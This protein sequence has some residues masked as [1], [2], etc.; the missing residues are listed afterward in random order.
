MYSH[1]NGDQ[2]LGASARNARHDRGWD[3]C[4][5]YQWTQKDGTIVWFYA[6]FAACS[7][8]PGYWGR[9]YQ[10]VGRNV[11]NY[12]LFT[13]NWV[14]G[15]A[16]SIQNLSSIT[17]SHSDGHS[18]TLTFGL[19]NGINE[20]TSIT[21]PDNQTT[22]GYSYDS[23][24]DLIGVTR[25]G[26]SSNA[27]L[28]E[29]YTYASGHQMTGAAGPRATTSLNENGGT[30]N[31][32]DE[33]LFF[34]N[35]SDQTTSLEDRGVVNFAPANDGLGIALQTPEPTGL[36]YWRTEGFSGYNGNTTVTDT[37]GHARTWTYDGSGRG[38]QLQAWSS[39]N[40]SL[41]TIAAW[42]S[43]NDLLSIVDPR[44]NE[45]DYG[46][47]ARG[48]LVAM[49]QPTVTTSSGPLRPTTTYSYDGHN[50][51]LSYCDPV[52]NATNSWYNPANPPPVCPT[53]AGS[54]GAATYVYDNVDSNE[55]FGVIVQSYSPMN[56]ETTYGY[57][58]GPVFDNYGLPTQIAGASYTQND[59]TTRTPIT[60]LA[61]N[62][63][64]DLTSYSNGNGTW[65]MT[66]DAFNRLQTTVDPD[67]G[68]PTSYTYYNPDG[69][70]SKTETPYQHANGWGTTNSYD[71]DGNVTKS[72]VYRMTTYSST[73][74]Q[75]PT[76]NWY[77]G[78]DRLV[79][80]QQAPDPNNDAYQNPWTTRYLYD[81]SQTSGVFINPG[82]LPYQAYG[83]LYKR[84]SC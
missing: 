10:V 50:N 70:V 51:L 83:N 68:N 32:G 49:A 4:G 11:N 23:T 6:P 26:N 75:Y 31:D 67:P 16:S 36:Q 1:Y 21:L 84:R 56:Y 59:G 35:G 53:A 2:L 12:I 3:G 29:S 48:N 54:A 28:P 79:E 77:D 62:T 81:I 69:T 15:N 13:Y 19:V 64:G 71:A 44:S 7:T 14:G 34:E 39:A 30:P 80:V 52:Y 33:V 63:Y 58:N 60:T 47:D 9:L 45:T 8:P 46:Y 22:I 17:A 42:D 57:A 20:L 43:N 38:T 37:Y 72:S 74:A 40:A 82:N 25:P 5:G 27:S 18:L 78:E 61:Y 73:P 66:Y 24:G 65:I 41:I 55:P 76:T